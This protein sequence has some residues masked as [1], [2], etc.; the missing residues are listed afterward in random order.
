M[1]PPF[2]RSATCGD[3]S[4]TPHTHTHTLQQD[5]LFPQGATAHEAAFQDSA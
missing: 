2:H 4:T 3:V 5:G 1:W